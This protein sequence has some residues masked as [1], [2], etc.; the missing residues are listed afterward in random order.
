MNAQD[1]IFNAFPTSETSQTKIIQRFVQIMLC[2][3]IGLLGG[4]I[5]VAITIVAAIVVQTLLFPAVVYVPEMAHFTIA[6]TIIGVVVSW[7]LHRAA[8]YVLR[9]SLDRGS[10]YEMSNVMAS[11]VLVGLLQS[12]LFT[13]NL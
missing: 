11:S 1:L 9:N 4:S 7:N 12:V 2:S 10:S 13:F 6:A 8:Q 5:G 3:G